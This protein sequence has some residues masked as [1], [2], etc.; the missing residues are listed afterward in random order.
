MVIHCMSHYTIQKQLIKKENEIMKKAWSDIKS[1]ITVATFI[2]F[3]YCVILQLEI[4]QELQTVLT[5][6]VGFFLGAQSVKN[7]GE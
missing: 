7:G 3:A 1:F 4:P 2:L 6:V 5:T